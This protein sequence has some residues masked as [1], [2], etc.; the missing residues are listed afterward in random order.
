M[1]PCGLITI[2]I[3]IV[4][5][6]PDLIRVSHPQLFTSAHHPIDAQL[7]P[8]DTI[9]VNILHNL[10]T[11]VCNLDYQLLEASNIVYNAAY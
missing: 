9:F 5:S 10:C 1:L 7:F 8:T 4:L 2:S 11:V 6:H 3:S